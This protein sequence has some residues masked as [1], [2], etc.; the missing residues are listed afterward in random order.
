MALIHHLH[1][2]EFFWVGDNYIDKLFGT[3]L[4]KTTIAQKKSPDTLPPQWSHDIYLFNQFRKPYL[5]YP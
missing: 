2:R 1:P 3:S 4:L 5:I